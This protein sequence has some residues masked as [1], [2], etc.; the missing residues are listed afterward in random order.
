MVR[1]STRSSSIFPPNTLLEQHIHV[2]SSCIHTAIYSTHIVVFFYSLNTLLPIAYSTSS[3][4]MTHVHN[5]PRHSCG[6]TRLGPR[7]APLSHLPLPPTLALSGLVIL[8]QRVESVLPPANV[9]LGP[10]WTVTH[11]LHMY[12]ACCGDELYGLG[13]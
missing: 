4:T 2:A 11:R 8:M 5:P 3:G 7:C 6:R 13:H 12:R 1:S 9:S 10:C